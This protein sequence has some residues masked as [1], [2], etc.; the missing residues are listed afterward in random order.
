LWQIAYA[1]YVSDYSR[2]MPAALHHLGHAELGTLCRVQGH[3]NAADQIPGEDGDDRRE[4]RQLKTQRRQGPGDD[5][6]YHDVRA[7]PYREQIA[8]ASVPLSGR[9]RINGVLFDACALVSH[10]SIYA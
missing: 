8:G 3:E 2:Y 4:Q 6:Q 7:E 1:P 5:G 10:R 9:D